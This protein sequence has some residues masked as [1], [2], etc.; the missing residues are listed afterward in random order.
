M[1][2]IRSYYALFIKNANLL[3]REDVLDALKEARDQRAF[4]IWNH[5]GWKAQQPDSTVW[6]AE[7]T[8]LLANKYSYN[9]V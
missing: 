8:H 1:Y 9:F 4:L 6:F 2:A 3:E 7:H 5:P